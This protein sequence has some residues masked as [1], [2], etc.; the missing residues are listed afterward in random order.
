[1][2]I[3]AALGYQ[4]APAAALGLCDLILSYF[5]EHV[6]FGVWAYNQR[7]GGWFSDP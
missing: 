4:K 7:G 2:V 6:I 1:M 3:P 5:L